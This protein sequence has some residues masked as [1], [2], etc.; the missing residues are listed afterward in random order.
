[1]ICNRCGAEHHQPNI[2]F[3]TTVP[4]KQLRDMGKIDVQQCR[5]C[6]SRDLR[7][8]GSILLNDASQNIQVN[9]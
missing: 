4:T 8:A 2:D 6:G 7:D 3:C 1:M 5:E 9:L